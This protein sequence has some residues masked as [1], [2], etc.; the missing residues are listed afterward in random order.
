MK[1]SSEIPT[2]WYA[3]ISS[4]IFIWDYLWVTSKISNDIHSWANIFHMFFA[5]PIPPVTTFSVSFLSRASIANVVFHLG[6]ARLPPDKINRNRSGETYQR[7]DDDWWI[8]NFYTTVYLLIPNQMVR[9]FNKIG[10]NP[11]GFDGPKLVPWETWRDVKVFFDFSSFSTLK[12][13]FLV[14]LWYTLRYLLYFMQ[15]F[16]WL[17]KYLKF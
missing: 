10:N 4:N 17:S 3:S 9:A 14:L 5:S 7:L 12:F 8:S 11:L 13:F 6:P 16:E 1:F 15:I 2:G